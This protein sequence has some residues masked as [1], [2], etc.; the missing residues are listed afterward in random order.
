M[1][2]FTDHEHF[3]PVRRSELINMLCADP[4][5]PEPDREPFRQLCQLVSAIHHVEF[6][7]QMEKLKAAYAPFD[8]DTDTQPLERV[9][10]EEKQRRL[11]ELFAQIAW[12]MER[13]NYK[14]MSTDEIEPAIGAHSYWGLRVLVDFHE[15]ERLH[16][17]DRSETTERRECRL[18][19]SFYR[20]QEVD[21][22]V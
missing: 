3:I 13:A 9:K 18:A 15:F 5:V 20:K 8:P 21:V 19:G 7:Q 4:D 14:H 6:Y 2:E 10:Y 17:F 1:L 16:L 12:L 22:P 11:N